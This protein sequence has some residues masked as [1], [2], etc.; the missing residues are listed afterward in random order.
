MATVDWSRK[1]SDVPEGARR[2]WR[3]DR[4]RADGRIVAKEIA[5]K[6]GLSE[7]SIR[8][9]LREL[10]AAGLA[11]RVYG[12]ALPASPAVADTPRRPR[13]HPRACGGWPQPQQ[14]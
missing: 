10:D 13:S 3:A 14:P 5:A 2:Q 1:T 4:P 11:V 12:A 7:D 8:R 9:D 6:L